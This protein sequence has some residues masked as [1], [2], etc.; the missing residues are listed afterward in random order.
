MKFLIIHGSFGSPQGNWFPKLQEKLES[1]NQEVLVPQFPVD[2]WGEVTRQGIDTNTKHQNLP[3][4]LETF[5]TLVVPWI[6]KEKVVI[7]AHSLGPLFALHA[8]SQ[9]ELNI[10]AAIFVA[11]FLSLPRNMDHWQIDTANKSFYV[12]QFDYHRL[13]QKIPLSYALYSLN[14]PYV[15][16]TQARAFAHKLGSSLIPITGAKHLSSEFANNDFPLVFELCKTRIPLNQY[17]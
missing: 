10:D 2:D 3:T 9:W 11:P 15:P 16:P 17:Q 4:W 12:H 7:V 14:D 6:G 1:L 5:K 8:A 13:K